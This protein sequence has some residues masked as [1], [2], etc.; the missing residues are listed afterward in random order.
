[1]SAKQYGQALRNHWG[2]ENNL[3][4]QLDI[5]FGEDAN[6]M[7]AKT[8]AM[9]LAML[10]KLALMLLKEDESKGSIKTKRTKAALNTDFLAKILIGS[11]KVEKV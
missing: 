9:N 6:R 11:E 1:M 3:H 10:R 4:W 2:I 5:S 7:Q 8:E